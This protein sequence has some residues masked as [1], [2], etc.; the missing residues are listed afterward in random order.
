MYYLCWG[1]LSFR[2]EVG[3]MNIHKEFVDLKPDSG[4]RE[5]G[6]SYF[7]IQ[8]DHKWQKNQF[9][10]TT[11]IECRMRRRK[12]KKQEKIERTS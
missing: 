11:H 2:I 10:P 12:E 3:R 5:R 4:G 6:D 8:R 7:S 9:T 1:R